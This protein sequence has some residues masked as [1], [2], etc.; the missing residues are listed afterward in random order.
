MKSSSTHWDRIF[1]KTEDHQLGWYEKDTT[2]TFRLLDD[3][4]DLENATVFVPGAGTSILIEDL[5]SKVQQLIL[6]DISSKALD[7]VKQRQQ[8][9]IEKAIWLHQDISQPINTLLPKVDVWIDRAVLHFL[10]DKSDIDGYFE[11]L[12]SQLRCGGFAVFAEFSLQGAS[13]CAGL[14]LHRYSVDELSEHLGP[15]FELISHF[16]YTYTM[17]SGAPRPYIYALFKRVN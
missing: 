2:Q 11:N 14:P 6:N 10:T 3:I 7:R 16:D 1:S 13:K 15:A 17:P 12:K 9:G 8:A 5:A 4:P